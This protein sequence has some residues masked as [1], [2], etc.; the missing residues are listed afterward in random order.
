MRK[1]NTT[2]LP[3]VAEQIRTLF[4]EQGPLIETRKRSTL[5]FGAS[6]YPVGWLHITEHTDHWHVV[7]LQN[8]TVSAAHDRL[9]F[10]V[11]FWKD[12]G[13]RKVGPKPLSGVW[14][15]VPHQMVPT[16]NDERA[17]LVFSYVKKKIEEAYMSHITH[18]TPSVKTT[19]LDTPCPSTI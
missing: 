9:A 15:A 17:A 7:P 3:N 11:D 10:G 16:D 5:E 1:K 19:A 2:T 4:N 8:K 12:T 13:E 6:S 14:R 18:R